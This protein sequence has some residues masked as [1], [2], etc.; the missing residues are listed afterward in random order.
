MS[1]PNL[2]RNLDTAQTVQEGFNRSYNFDLSKLMVMIAGF[3]GTNA[4]LE[5]SKLTAVKVTVSGSDTYIGKAAIGSAQS[6]AVWQA[7]KV[8]VTGGDTVITWADGD[9]NFDNIATDLTLLTYS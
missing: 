5:T 8:T 1:D 6:A 3:D 4:L 2:K 9:G 7:K